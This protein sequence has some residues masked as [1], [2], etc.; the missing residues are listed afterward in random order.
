MDRVAFESRASR[1][2]GER[3]ALSQELHDAGMR[4]PHQQRAVLE[5]RSR[6]A[7]LGAPSQLA[8]VH[9]Q[10]GATG[11]RE[12]GRAQH[13]AF[14]IERRARQRRFDAEAPEARRQTAPDQM[15]GL[16]ECRPETWVPDW[17]G[18]GVRDFFPVQHGSPAGGP[19]DDVDPG[20]AAGFE[21]Q[22]FCGALHEP[23][24]DA[25][26]RPGVQAQRD[27]SVSGRI[28]QQVGI[29]LHVE[30]AIAVGFAPNLKFG[31]LHARIVP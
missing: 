9:H 19:A 1:R 20:T 28:F 15:L 6:G 8:S 21:I 18:E 13:A 24:R 7:P 3:F 4:R 30:G 10:L 11:R 22:E 17:R 12:A 31:E 25:R 16:G 27:A 26:R 23:E 2:D 29:A 5:E 14:G